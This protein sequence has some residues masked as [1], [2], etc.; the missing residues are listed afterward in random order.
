M[1]FGT[2]GNFVPSYDNTF[3]CGAGGNRFNAVYATSGVVNTSDE[4]QK[5]DIATS[6]L[7]LGFINTLTP[8]SYKWINRQNVIDEETQELVPTPGVRTHYGLIAQEVETAL[9]GKDFAGFVH[10]E[11]EDAYGLRYEQFISPLI[12]AVQ[13]LSAKVDSLTSELNALKGN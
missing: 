11:E 13:E 8:R 3:S 12:K 2:S 6:D 10:D 1:G 9:N 7:G 5:T 4:R